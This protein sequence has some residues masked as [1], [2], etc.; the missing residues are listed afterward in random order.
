[1]AEAAPVPEQ[2]APAPVSVPDEVPVATAPTRAGYTPPSPAVAKA[3]PSSPAA[4]AARPAP[5]RRPSK[6][7]TAGP[8]ESAPGPLFP[9][10]RSFV[11]AIPFDL[12]A[13]EHDNPASSMGATAVAIATHFLG[14]PYV[15][16]G[17]SPAGGFDCS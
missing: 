4:R 7:T 2:A 9:A 5:A 11:P 1:P 14:T 15:W 10:A 16:G 8:T 3:A 6:S 17:A 13:W 12:Q